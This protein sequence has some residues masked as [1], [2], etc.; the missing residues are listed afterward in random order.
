MRCC[1]RRAGPA[2][3]CSRT[4]RRAG[5]P[6]RPRCGRW[7]GGVPHATRRVGTPGGRGVGETRRR[8]DWILLGAVVALLILGAEMVYSASFVVAHNEFND[9]MYFLN[10]QAMW[11]VIGA[12]AMALAAR[13]DYRRWRRLSPLAM[14]IS[15]V[16]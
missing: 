15:V 9:D 13:F 4:S 16:L 6:S 10:R 5:G 11:M 8:A 14:A 12:I 1:S 3:T 2:S 7:P